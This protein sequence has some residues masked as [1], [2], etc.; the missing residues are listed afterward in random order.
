MRRR[1]VLVEAMQR[2]DAEQT[3]CATP[4]MPRADACSAGVERCTT[5]RSKTLPEDR[6]GYV[7]RL[8]PP[9]AS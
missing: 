8:F 2:D 7:N 5:R 6:G 4:P 1:G 3:T 9:P